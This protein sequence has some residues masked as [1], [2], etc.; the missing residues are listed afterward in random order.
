M[1]YWIKKNFFKK[2]TNIVEVK[3]IPDDITDE[4][5][6]SLLELKEAFDLPTEEIEFSLE[7]RRLALNKRISRF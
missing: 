4:I 3:D 2:T 7:S 6:K 1:R 5:E